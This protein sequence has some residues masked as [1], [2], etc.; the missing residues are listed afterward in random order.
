MKR[1]LKKGNLNMQIAIDIMKSREFYILMI[2]MIGV[3][4]IMERMNK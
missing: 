2:G 3:W 1:F 4:V